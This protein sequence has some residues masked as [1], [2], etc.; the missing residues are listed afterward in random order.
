[1]SNL[2]HANCRFNVTLPQV[3]A[4]ASAILTL[5]C[6]TPEDINAYFKVVSLID[7]LNCMFVSDGVGKKTPSVFFDNS[8]SFKLGALE[9]RAC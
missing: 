4:G 9:R 1:M 6:G 8:A 3:I 2:V 7:W 5:G